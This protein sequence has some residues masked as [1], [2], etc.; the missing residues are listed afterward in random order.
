MAGETHSIATIAKVL[1]LSER[2]VQQLVKEGIIP[3]HERGRFELIPAVHGYIKFLKGKHIGKEASENVI[4]LDEAR[5]RKLTAEASMAE[6]ELETER[7]NLVEASKVENV[8]S[9]I[10]GGIRGKMLAVPSQIAPLVIGENKQAVVKDI[11]EN[12]ILEGLN[13]LSSDRAKFQPKPGESGNENAETHG[14]A[15]EDNGEPGGGHTQEVVA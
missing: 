10:C 14:P 15:A 2:R 1:D 12:A 6:L 9:E 13:D 8:W 5:R 4:S 7:G 11:I 3:K